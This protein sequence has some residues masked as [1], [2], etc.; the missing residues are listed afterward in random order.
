MSDAMSFKID[1]QLRD[2]FVKIARQNNR[3]A[4]QLLRDFVVS[5]VQENAQL[6]I[7]KPGAQKASHQR[8]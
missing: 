6:R 3:N 8:N 2:Q 4:S 5:Y 1:K 7:P